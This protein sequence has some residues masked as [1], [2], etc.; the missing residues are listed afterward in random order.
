LR[1]LAEANP[2]LAGLGQTVSEN[3]RTAGE[4]RAAQQAITAFGSAA[5]DCA[6]AIS[7]VFQD[8]AEGWRLIGNA[9]VGRSDGDDWE[10]SGDVFRWKPGK[11]DAR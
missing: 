11:R 8:S 1:R 6:R 9:V 5:A 7:A 10:S 4:L 2:G 3:H